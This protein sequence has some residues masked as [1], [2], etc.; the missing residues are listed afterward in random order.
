[1]ASN[2]SYWIDLYKTFKRESLCVD[3]EVGEFGGDISVIGLYIPKGGIVECES[4]VRGKNLTMENLKPFFDKAKFII[5]FNG[6]KWD[7]PKIKSEF[8][9][10]IPENL[11]VFDLYI[12]GRA[13]NFKYNLRTM[14][15]TFNIGRLTSESEKKGIA[16]KLWNEHRRGDP[17]ALKKLLEYNAQ[18]TVNLYFLAEKLIEIADSISQ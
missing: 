12:F 15:N 13:L 11:K 3:I 17:N 10:L 1:M 14:E 2:L 18:D 5:T 8:P 4:F 16:I 9:G 6:L 7:I